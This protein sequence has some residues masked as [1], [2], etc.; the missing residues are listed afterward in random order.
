MS[1]LTR[2]TKEHRFAL[3]LPGFAHHPISGGIKKKMSMECWWN[4]TDRGKAK[5]S[6]INYANA[7]FPT[8]NFTWIGPGTNPDLRGEKSATNGMSRGM[9]GL[10]TEVHANNTYKTLS[11]PHK[12]CNPRRLQTLN[13]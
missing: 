2:C 4:D 6:E 3:K 5:Y 8:T 12:E 13:S 9:A 10:K 7:T 1:V 11:L